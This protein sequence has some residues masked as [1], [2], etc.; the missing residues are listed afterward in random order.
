MEKSIGGETGALVK[1]ESLQH[2]TSGASEELKIGIGD[3]HAAEVEALQ[4]IEV[5]RDFLNPGGDVASPIL[6]NQVEHCGAGLPLQFK[7]LQVRKATTEPRRRGGV[8]EGDGDV[9]PG[10]RVELVPTST[11]L[12]NGI[13][14]L[15][16]VDVGYDAVENHVDH[17]CFSHVPLL[18]HGLLLDRN[19][20]SEEQKRKMQGRKRDD[21]ECVC[22]RKREN[23]RTNRNRMGERRKL[24][25]S[26]LPIFT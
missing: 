3:N 1:L 19:L 6:G 22:K 8:A 9:L 4:A 15:R 23:G 2:M 14:V 21:G 25:V 26:L 5:L 12:G 17:T 10:K 11:H 24:V 20:R 18:R 16:V 7:R 13:P